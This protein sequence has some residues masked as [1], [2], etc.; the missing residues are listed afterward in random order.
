MAVTISFMMSNKNSPVLQQM[1]RFCPPGGMQ[2]IYLQNI[3][4]LTVWSSSPIIVEISRRVLFFGSP[5]V[6]GFFCTF[7]N[8]NFPTNKGFKVLKWGKCGCRRPRPNSRPS[9]T[10]RI[11]SNDVSVTLFFGDDRFVSWIIAF[12]AG[13]AHLH[14]TLSAVTSC[15]DSG[16]LF[17]GMCI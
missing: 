1:L 2:S 7:Y 9:K 14:Q 4:L 16:A 3:L 6:W 15:F 10:F 13:N 12:A 8:L 5:R 17:N 11:A